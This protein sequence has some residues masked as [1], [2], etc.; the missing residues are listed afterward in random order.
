MQT[1]Y[2]GGTNF[3]D[4]KC[5]DH[6]QCPAAL[7][8]SHVVKSLNKKWGSSPTKAQ[9]VGNLIAAAWVGQCDPWPG[10]VS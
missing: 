1:L 6:R 8:T 10:T 5:L 2:Y 7:Y 3:D 9:W 4:N